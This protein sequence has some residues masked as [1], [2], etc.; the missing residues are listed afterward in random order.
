MTVYDEVARWGDLEVCGAI[1]VQVTEGN[2]FCDSYRVRCIFMVGSIHASPWHLVV[3][4]QSSLLQLKFH[5]PLHG[6]TYGV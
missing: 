5:G 6:A 2:L 4:G 3:S 1:L